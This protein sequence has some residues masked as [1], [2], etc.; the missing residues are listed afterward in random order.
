M[1]H[2]Q[3]AQ[4]KKTQ[5]KK[6]QITIYIIIGILLLVAATLFF[7]FDSIVDD[8]AHTQ[9]TLQNIQNI[10]CSD[11]TKANTCSQQR[12]NNNQ[13]LFCTQ[14]AELVA[15]CAQCGC[16]DSQLCTGTTCVSEQDIEE[17]EFPFTIYF[18]P[19]N[20]D[21]S[22]TTSD[23]YIAFD[24]RV[25]LAQEFLK[26][27]LQLESTAFYTLNESLDVLVGCDINPAVLTLFVD[28]YLQRYFNTALPAPK[29]FT[30][31]STSTNNS[32]PLYPYRIVGLDKLAQNTQSCGCGF[33]TFYGDVAYLGGADCSQEAAIVAHELGHTF[34]LCD[35]YDT[36][37]WQ[38]QDTRF[39][40][41][42]T[43]P[44]QI[45]SD[46]SNSCCSESGVCC[47][48]KFAQTGFNIMGSANVPPH[49]EINE[50]SFDITRSHLCEHLGVCP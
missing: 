41:L 39:S 29:K 20:Y 8:S 16:P 43:Q 22:S 9:A 18:V 38:E 46:C 25:F 4:T 24:E 49:R 1:I 34:G 3:Q 45:D 13:Q 23:D 50:E 27:E 2:I 10:Q 31:T 30:S 47:H 37:I 33:T 48:G 19:L 5:T 14:Q 21:L 6:A 7:S 15:S 17:K 40:C 35:E 26:E 12:N 32:F 44:N 36:C 11:G 28:D 42:N